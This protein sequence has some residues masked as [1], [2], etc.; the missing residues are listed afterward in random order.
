MPATSSD[1]DAFGFGEGS[2][3]LWSGIVEQPSLFSYPG[4]EDPFREDQAPRSAPRWYSQRDLSEAQSIL[5]LLRN[6]DEPLTKLQLA[7]LR[8]PE[9]FEMPTYMF[10]DPKGKNWDFAD[11]IQK[12]YVN[13]VG[14]LLR[15]ISDSIN[16]TLDELGEEP[17][18]KLRYLGSVSLAIQIGE[19]SCGRSLYV[20]H[21]QDLPQPPESLERFMTW[22]EVHR[23]KNSRLHRLASELLDVNSNPLGMQLN[24]E[25]YPEETYDLWEGDTWAEG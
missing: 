11:V 7:Q 14:L 8:Y 24:N 16:R 12:H 19:D 20:Y 18:Q 4:M 9:I 21:G 13:R 5:A 2:D 3:P 6:S 1:S 10:R 22:A 25:D 23:S 17:S 15:S